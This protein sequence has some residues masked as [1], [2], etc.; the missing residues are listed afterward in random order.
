MS[1]L[2]TLPNRPPPKLKNPKM[3]TP[4]FN[5]FLA[6]ILVKDP[7]ERPS[8]VDALTVFIFFAT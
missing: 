4:S 3:W 1:A 6:K 5:D 7:N 2:L 8:A